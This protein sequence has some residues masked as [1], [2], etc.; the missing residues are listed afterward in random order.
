MA[1]ENLYISKFKRSLDHQ[2]AA[3]TATVAA[4]RRRMIEVG[5]FL[6]MGF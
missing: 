3:G 4:A 2:L 6:F 5:S 1:Q